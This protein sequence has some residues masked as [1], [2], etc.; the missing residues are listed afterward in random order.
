MTGVSFGDLVEISKDRLGKDEAYLL[1]ATRLRNDLGWSDTRSLR[2]GLTET[3]AW[4]EDN[5]SQLRNCP[6]DYI[7]V[8]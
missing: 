8:P 7:H 5:L 1:D 4:I 2:R 3:L 6:N